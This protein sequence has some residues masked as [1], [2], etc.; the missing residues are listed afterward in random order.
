MLAQNFRQRNS[1]ESYYHKYTPQTQA[2]IQRINWSHTEVINQILFNPNEYVIYT[3]CAK[4]DHVFFFFFI[5]FIKYF[6]WFRLP[7]IQTK[8][9]YLNVCIDC[10]CLNRL[11]SG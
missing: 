1:M 2:I 9:K 10:I 7:S 8:E 5:I 4:G 6:Y 11:I 3:K